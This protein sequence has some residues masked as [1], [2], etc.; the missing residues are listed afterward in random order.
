[1]VDITKYV[2]P[3]ADQ[4]NADD[5][6]SDEKK[7]IKINRI[8]ETGDKAQ[9]ISIYF[10]GDSGKPWKPCLGMRRV[11]RDLWGIDAAKKAGVHYIGR[12]V[13]LYKDPNVKYGGELVGG[14]R[15]SGAS[16]I[17]KDT[18]VSVLIARMK[19]VMSTVKKLVINEPSPAEVITPEQADII[20]TLLRETESDVVKFLSYFKIKSVDEMPAHLA[21][22]AISILS[23]KKPKENSDKQDE[24][25][26]ENDNE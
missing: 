5:F 12:Y 21:D 6:G 14:V 2:A 9:P 7:L 22:K 18:Q 23:N 1:M 8:T 15:I 10:D 26:G 3:K 19:R 11:L 13:E 20:K 25:K 16:H 17:E 24:T 4:L